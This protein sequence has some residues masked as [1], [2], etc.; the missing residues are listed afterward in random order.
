LVSLH[1]HR[2][3]GRCLG[4]DGTV[5]FAQTS[6]DSLGYGTSADW[7]L[8][9][10]G[11]LAG[12][13]VAYQVSAVNGKGYSS[14]AR[15]ESVDFEGR[16]SFEPMKG[17]TL[18]VGGYSGKLGNDTKSNSPALHTATRTNALIN[19][20]AGAFKIGGSWWEAKNWKNVTTVATDKASAYSIWG[21][22]D[23]AKDLMLFARYDQAKPNKD[24]AP[25]KKLT[26]YNLGV[27]KQFNKVLSANIAYK[28]AEVEG[29]TIGTGNGTIGLTVPG[30]K[31]KY[32]EVGV[33]AVY[34]F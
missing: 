24:T 11:K 32:Q 27:E 1:E 12:G 33:W 23:L 8:H 13:K 20:K 29:G 31:G 17:L 26:Y 21:Q 25:S 30:K 34:N 4:Q 19:Y 15:S 28:Y 7:G 18:A 14:P 3:R 9:L 2:R 6:S 22:Y 16:I 10:L 5:V